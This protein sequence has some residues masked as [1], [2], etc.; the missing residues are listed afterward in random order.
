MNKDGQVTVR[1]CI[2]GEE[3][4]IKGDASVEYIRSL[5]HIV[6]THMKS[7]QEGNPKLT[8]HRVAI[9]T[10]LNLA[11]ELEKVRAEY[12]ELL[13]IMEEANQVR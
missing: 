2:G 3:H 11:D 1:V 6:D 9:L 12:K 10:A 13:Q 8:R 5:A 4:P 7:I